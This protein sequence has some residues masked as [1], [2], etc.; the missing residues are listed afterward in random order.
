VKPNEALKEKEAA[1]LLH[2]TLEEE[3]EADEELS[4]IAEPKPMELADTF[5]HYIDLI[6]H[7]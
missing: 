4:A 7:R 5:D 3:K 1:S 6:R 2:Y